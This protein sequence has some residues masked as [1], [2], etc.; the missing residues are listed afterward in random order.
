MA[1]YTET[2]E[3]AAPIERVFE[4]RLDFT[5]LPSYNPDVPACAPRGDTPAGEGCV[6]DFLLRYPGRHMRSEVLTVVAAEY[7]R[8]IVIE[9]DALMNATE[10]CHFEARGP[11]RTFVVFEADVEIPGG[12]L[13]PV[14]EALFVKRA[15]H[16]QVS[17]ELRLMAELLDTSAGG[18]RS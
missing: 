7:P 3:I 16:R 12:R 4:Y 9:L 2:T 18:E 10:T 17:R 1:T 11:G 14:L 6:Y 15:W 8:L 13:A 5:N